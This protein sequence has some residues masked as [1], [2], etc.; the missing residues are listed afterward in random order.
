M[1][2][3]KMLVAFKLFDASGFQGNRVIVIE[4]IN[5][6]NGFAALQQRVAGREI[7]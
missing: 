5:T 1:R 7:R 2:E 4:T 6:E 3:T